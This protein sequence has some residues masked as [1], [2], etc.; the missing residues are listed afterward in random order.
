MLST[1]TLKSG[2][3][4]LE[5]TGDEA[6]AIQRLAIAY[7]DYMNDA[8][9]NGL[10]VLPGSMLLTPFNN[11]KT[12]MVGIGDF[13]TTAAATKLAAGL[14]AFWAAMSA[15]PATIFTG[16]TAITPPV[17][18]ATVGTGIQAAFDANVAAGK[19]LSDAAQALADAI[20]VGSLG[21]TATFPGPIVS[22]IS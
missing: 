13:N 11:M 1:A 2:L 12:A 20:S 19:G 7:E 21:G 3:E 9:S 6:V 17:T 22:P 8:M 15:A 4:A 14:T 10:S 16:A 18:L 5:A